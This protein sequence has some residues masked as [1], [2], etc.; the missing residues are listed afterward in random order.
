[1]VS[2]ADGILMTGVGVRRRNVVAFVT[3]GITPPE[4]G[5]G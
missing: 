3:I 5:S 1:M 2:V 4:M